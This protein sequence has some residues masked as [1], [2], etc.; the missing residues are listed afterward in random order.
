MHR[1]SRRGTLPKSI[2]KVK[3]IPLYAACVFATAHR[4]PW[5]TKAKDN[6]SI[7]RKDTKPGEE[8]SCDHIVSHQ[9]GL[10]PQSLSKLTHERFWGLVLFVDNYSDFLYNYHLTSITSLGT[11]GEKHTYERI[12]DTHGIDVKLYHTDNLRFSDNFLRKIAKL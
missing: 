7:R 1:L 2:Q 11:L 8:T 12:S 6:R 4:K 5:R 10:M 3:G 9:P